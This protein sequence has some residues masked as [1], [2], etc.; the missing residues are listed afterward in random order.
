MYLNE[1][2]C[3]LKLFVGIVGQGPDG[4]LRAVMSMPQS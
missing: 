3:V 1:L 2:R 4:Y